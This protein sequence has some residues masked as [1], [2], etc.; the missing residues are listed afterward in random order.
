[1]G[2]WLFDSFVT[3]LEESSINLQG[4]S[5]EDIELRLAISLCFNTSFGSL[6]S[7]HM[8]RVARMQGASSD[9]VESGSNRCDEQL[10]IPF[11]G[12]DVDTLR[13]NCSKKVWRI[14]VTKKTITVKKG[15]TTF[16]LFRSR[17]YFFLSSH[18]VPWGILMLTRKQIEGPT[19]NVVLQELTPVSAQNLVTKTLNVYI[20]HCQKCILCRISLLFTESGSPRV[21][22]C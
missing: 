4:C 9:C 2:P 1:M 5:A 11:R 17:I 13:W 12:Q 6:E 21:V 20:F 15:D 8:G 16:I 18:N 19:S 3:M 22:Y 10:A 14:S 7:V